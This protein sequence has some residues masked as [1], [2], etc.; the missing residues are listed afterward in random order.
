MLIICGNMPTL[1]Q[2]YECLS[3]TYLFNF[4]FN[5]KFTE[6]LKIVFDFI[7][8]YKFQSLI[9]FLP[10]LNFEYLTALIF[11]VTYFI[12]AVKDCM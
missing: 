3:N 6:L 12:K 7:S 9:C 11:R 10:K 1:N 2:L 5:L 4:L 8:I